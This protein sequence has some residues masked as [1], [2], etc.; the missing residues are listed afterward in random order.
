MFYTNT[1]SPSRRLTLAAPAARADPDERQLR[2]GEPEAGYF[3]DL[4]PDTRQS[5]VMN[6]CYA[7]AFGANDVMVRVIGRELVV[8]A[9]VTEIRSQ[10]EA[11]LDED[12]KG[13]VDRGPVKARMAASNDLRHVIGA[14]MRVRLSY[15]RIPDEPSLTSE[16]AAIGSDRGHPFFE[17][18]L[19]VVMDQGEAAA[20]AVS[21]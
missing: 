6:V 7:T 14:Q 3:L 2:R 4:T 8:R 12:G 13:A 10:Q 16:P 21:P 9:A 17:E 11:L 20:P 5:V 15:E 18:R 1:C 19:L